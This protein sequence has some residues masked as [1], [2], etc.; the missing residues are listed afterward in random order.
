VVDCDLA[1][2]VVGDRAA[3]YEG[4][5][6]GYMGEV[7][8]PGEGYR[9]ARA[10]LS[11]PRRPLV[12]G[13]FLHAGKAVSGQRLGELVAAGGADLGRP[14]PLRRRQPLARHHPAPA[15]P[16]LLPALVPLP[17]ASFPRATRTMIPPP[18][19]RNLR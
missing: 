13:G 8:G 4:A 1:S 12:L 6:F 2:L 7:D 11:A 10:R 14:P 3:T 9:F 19:A 16:N 17:G 15:P 18:F 5:E